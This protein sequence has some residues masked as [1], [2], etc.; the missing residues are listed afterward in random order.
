MQGNKTNSDLDSV[1]MGVPQGT[2]LGPMLYLIYTCTNDLDILCDKA[3]T[4]SYTDDTSFGYHAKTAE[5][6]QLKMNVSLSETYS[7]S[8]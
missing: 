2:V 8:K 4:I 5:E 1:N 3:F 6:L 7:I